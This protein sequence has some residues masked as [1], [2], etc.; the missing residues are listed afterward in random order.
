MSFFLNAQPLSL[1][2]QQRKSIILVYKKFDHLIS[3]IGISDDNVIIPISAEMTSA[4]IGK[5]R[6][7]VLEYELNESFRL[8][9]LSENTES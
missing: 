3:E 4:D 7:A 2:R 9:R 8:L 5:I 6:K 1:L